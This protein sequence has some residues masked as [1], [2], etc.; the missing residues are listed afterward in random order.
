MSVLEDIVLSLNSSGW[1][2]FDVSAPVR[3]SLA[4][5]ESGR[6]LGLR[7]EIKRPGA[8]HFR[9]VHWRRMRRQHLQPF[10]VVF[11]EDGFSME[12]DIEHNYLRVP[13]LEAAAPP[14]GDPGGATALASSGERVSSSVRARRSVADNRLPPA[15]DGYFRYKVDGSDERHVAVVSHY[16]DEMSETESSGST[17][18]DSR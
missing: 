6:L 18:G 5:A 9:P 11:T 2:I 12:E 4:S 17:E 10:M 8:G 14:G 3:L 1:Q 16:A 15:D 7:A 13:R